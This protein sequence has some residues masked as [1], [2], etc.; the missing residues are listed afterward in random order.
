MVSS[1][2]DNHPYHHATKRIMT[3]AIQTPQEEKQ[4]QQQEEGEEEYIQHIETPLHACSL[5]TFSHPIHRTF[6]SGDEDW[7]WPMM[8]G[9][10]ELNPDTRQRTGHL[11]LYAV[12]VVQHNDDDNNNNN[13]APTTFLD[14]PFTVLGPSNEG[15]DD[16][17]PQVSGILDGKWCCDDPN[18][19]EDEDDRAIC[20]RR[21][22]MMLYATAHATGEL[23]IH[24]VQQRSVANHSN[25]D[26]DEEEET[27]KKDIAKDTLVP[28][29][30]SKIGQSES[31]DAL[32]LSVSWDN[33]R[34]R[35]EEEGEVGCVRRNI[36]SSYSDGHVAI[37]KMHLRQTNNDDHNNNNN[38]DNL[39]VELEE[40]HS[41]TAHNMFTSPAEVWTASFTT[42]DQVV[43]TGGDEGQ[44]KIWDLRL[45]GTPRPRPIHSLS[46]DAGVTVLSPHPR[47]EHWI[48]CGSYDETVRILDLRMMLSSH[49]QQGPPQTL[50][51]SEPQGGGIWRIKWHPHNDN[52]LLLGAMHGG[53]RIVDLVTKE[54]CDEDSPMLELRAHQSFTRHKSMAYGADWL[55]SSGGTHRRI[56]MAASCSFYDKAL[57]IWNVNK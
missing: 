5:E 45:M 42:H 18:N 55:V 48:A 21:P 47:R 7:I 33:P 6:S 53:C 30:V 38:N 4:R 26:Q 19:D 10:Y 20:T 36:I 25:E 35:E 46:F 49:H 37:H 31:Q 2:D 24:H 23:Q 40:S 29:H 27:M 39:Q 41:W 22:P 54:W 17:G 14:P 34:R 13:H 1:H 28:W 43:L 57:Y 11:D 3:T 16:H 32:C 9:C 44:C 8:V 50:C 15:D 52:R 51:H 56:E 12:K